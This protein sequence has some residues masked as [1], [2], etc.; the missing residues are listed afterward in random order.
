MVK[1]ER[2]GVKQ[3]HPIPM[4]S[5]LLGIRTRASREG[6][7]GMFGKNQSSD[8]VRLPDQVQ[9]ADVYYLCVVASNAEIDAR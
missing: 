1:R 6:G 3:H 4:F 9:R 7:S 8:I 2:G 5:P